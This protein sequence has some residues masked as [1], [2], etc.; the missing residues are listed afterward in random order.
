LIEHAFLLLALP[1]ENTPATLNAVAPVT[2]G[3]KALIA[4]W[5]AVHGLRGRSGVA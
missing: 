2:E 1:M 3:L 4:K 5:R